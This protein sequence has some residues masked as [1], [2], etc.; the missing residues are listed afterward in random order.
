M[1]RGFSFTKCEVINP[2]ILLFDFILAWYLFFP[3]DRPRMPELE[4]FLSQRG[5]SKPKKKRGTGSFDCLI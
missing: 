2:P 5:T 1:P 4:E 3:E